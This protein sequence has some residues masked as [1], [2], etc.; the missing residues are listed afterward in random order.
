MSKKD[1]RSAQRG[2]RVEA[3]GYIESGKII[4]DVKKNL[5]AVRNLRAGILSFAYLLD[6][7]PGIEGYLVLVDPKISRKRLGDEWES[8][9]H[10]LTQ[11][12][13][14][15]LH[16]VIVEDGRFTGLPEGLPKMVRNQLARLTEAEARPG[17]SL[18]RPDY[19]FV[20]LKVLIHLWL[21]NAGPVTTRQLMETAG[22]TYPTVSKALKRLGHT[23]QRHSDR[24][25]HLGA[26]PREAWKQLLAVAD[27]VRVTARFA[28]RSGQPRSPE[29]LLHRLRRMKRDDIGVGGS[30]G[31]RHWYPGIDLVGNPRLDLT[32]HC[33][34][35]R[36][37]LDF[38]KQLD[39]ALSRSV[40]AH[41]PASVVIHV[42][43][44][45]DSMFEIDST[46]VNWADPVECLL[47]LQEM[48]LEPQALEFLSSFNASG[49]L[50]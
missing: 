50:I 47:D 48:H 8:A 42:L 37:D 31:A 40:N 10:A 29:A 1:Q 11:H 46:G 19:F 26:F 45:A 18:P 13:R 5:R 24:R 25:V 35:N 3:D 6:Q 32:V 27:D 36:L 7:R 14:R 38:M 33:P 9:S 17:I 34:A 43:R 4:L 12:V 21:H 16:L 49:G 20:V 28:D 22:C 39:P 23:V 44:R 30:L 15:R 2:M 41:Q